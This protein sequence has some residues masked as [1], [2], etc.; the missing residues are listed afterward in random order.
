[1][2]DDLLDAMRYCIFLVKK[3]QTLKSDPPLMK[4]FKEKVEKKFPKKNGGFRHL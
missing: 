1:V 3:N 4:K 2:N